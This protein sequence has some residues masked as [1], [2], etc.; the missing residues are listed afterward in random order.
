ME[1]ARANL[2]RDPTNLLG[3][4]VSCPRRILNDCEEILGTAFKD[5]ADPAWLR[6]GEAGFNGD[7][8]KLDNMGVSAAFL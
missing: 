6:G 1:Q 5:E 7:V 3:R 4:R 2:R 8:Q